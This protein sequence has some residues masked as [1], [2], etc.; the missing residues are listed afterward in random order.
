[1]RELEIAVEHWPI[2]GSFTIARGSRTEAVVVVATVREGEHAGWGECVPYKRYGESVDSVVAQLRGLAEA[3]RDGLMRTDLLRRLTPGAA[4]NAL[5]CALWDLEVHAS[6]RPLHALAGALKPAPMTTAYT[7]SL[8]TPESMY[9][10][11]R[12]AAERPLLKV[13]LGGDGDIERLAAVREGAPRARLIV[14]A[15]EGWRPDNLGAN[16][17]ACEREKVELIEQPLPAGDD[18]A[19]ARIDTP[20]AICADESIHD[21]ASL[22]AL[23]AWYTAVNIKLDKTGGLTDALVLRR[24]A[25]ARGLGIMVGCMVGTSLGMTPALVI[26][27]GADYVDL[28]G[29]LLLARDREG[30]LRYEGSTLIPP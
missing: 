25:A 20:V 27:E 28:D 24:E 13:K 30:G 5:D 10:A 16:I 29:P 23:P 17:A 18:G 22:A 15:N 4:R 19:L 11:A 7:L 21:A 3:V 14:D 2:A 1:M 12:R 9:E 6:G 8:G 26:A